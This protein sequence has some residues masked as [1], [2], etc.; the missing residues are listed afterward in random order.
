MFTEVTLA[1]GRKLGIPKHSA[2]LIEEHAPGAFEHVPD[3]KTFVLYE[4]EGGQATAFLTDSYTHLT[5]L[6]P[7][8]SG[9]RDWID[10]VKDD[11]GLPLSVPKDS[12]VSWSQAL[13]DRD[14]LF[15]VKVRVRPHALDEYRIKCTFAALR[16]I[17]GT[18][19][20]QQ[21]E[22]HDRQEA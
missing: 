7:K 11:S 8:A 2:T 13:A 10:L 12:I 21:E 3:A 6:F 19:T 18:E 14:D 15:D 17:T 22:E 20:S 9:G 1:D 4:L 5:R 16:E